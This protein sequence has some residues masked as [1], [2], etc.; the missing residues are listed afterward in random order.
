MQTKDKQLSGLNNI[1]LNKVKVQ[2]INDVDLPNIASN[3]LWVDEIRLG[4]M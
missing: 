2:S 3:R 1:I 4:A